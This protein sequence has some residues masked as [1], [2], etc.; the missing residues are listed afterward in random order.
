MT[1]LG[2]IAIGVGL[3]GDLWAFG[4][5]LGGGLE[6]AAWRLQQ[7]VEYAVDHWGVFDEE[8]PP[9]EGET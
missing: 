5:A 2:A 1:D 9:Q 4:Y 6:T 3:F 7:A 8:D